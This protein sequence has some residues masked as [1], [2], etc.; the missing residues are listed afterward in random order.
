MRAAELGIG[1][2]LPGNVLAGHQEGT[3]ES[4]E[5]WQEQSACRPGG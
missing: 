3:G 4:G 1:A 2:V 5:Y